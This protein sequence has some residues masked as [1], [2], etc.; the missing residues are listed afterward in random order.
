MKR[1]IFIGIWMLAAAT[2]A[3][4]QEVWGLARCIEY[5]LAN[6]LTLKQSDLSVM[7]SQI[8]LSQSEY[9]RH[10]SASGGTNMNLN[11]GR[12]VNPFTNQFESNTIFSNS[13]FVQGN[14]TLYAGGRLNNTIA[15]NKV[16]VEAAT[17]DRAQRSQDIA[18][19]VATAYLQ[20]LFALETLESAK[21]QLETTREQLARTR[22]LV[23]A[24][25]LP[26]A[27]I[28]QIEAQ[29]ATEDLAVVNAGNNAELAK[30]SLTQLMNLPVGQTFAIERPEI[31]DPAGGNL[32]ATLEEVYRTA[33]LNQ[34]GLSAAK[35]RQQA[36]TI[37]VDIARAGRLPTVNL[38]GSANTGYSSTAQGP[39]GAYRT[40]T[41]TQTIIF[42][43]EAQ[44]LQFTQTSPIYA[45][46]G[47]FKQLSNFGSMQVGLSV[48][49][50]IYDRHLTRSNIAQANIAVENARLQTA[51]LEQQLRQTIQQAYVNASAAYSRFSATQKQVAA[52]EAS[53]RNTEKQ[54]E[55]GVV[56][57]LDYLQAKNSLNRAR[58][59]VLQAK[60]EHLFRMKILDFYLGKELKL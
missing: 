26:Q 29:I 8:A 60:Y 54:Y 55:L 1:L 5:A 7:Q 21:I 24:G 41:V 31:A 10:P 50:P 28:A 4:A 40:D 43:G 23:A 38:S 45:R 34:P 6:N 56:N 13:F 25:T 48:S 19:N 37:G 44:E 17:Q 18:L 30:V 51:L 11:F 46:Q 9:N 39:T 42:N 35:A 49:V 33:L 15:Q 14:A 57:S 53:L 47:Y 22:K 59:D 3:Q 27:S 20:V 52:L 58:Y 2:A 16:N 32:P 36:A 12:S